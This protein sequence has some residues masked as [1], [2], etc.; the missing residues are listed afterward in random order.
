VKKGYGTKH[1]NIKSTKHQ[2][3]NTKTPVTF[4]SLFSCSQLYGWT[5]T[6]PFPHV[7]IPTTGMP[8]TRDGSGGSHDGY[9]DTRPTPPRVVA[10]QP[11]FEKAQL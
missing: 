10:A 9:G 4:Q 7:S 1:Q 11:E 2:K 8:P 6:R 5:H 3:Q